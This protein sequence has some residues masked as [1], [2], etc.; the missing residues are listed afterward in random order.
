MEDLLQQVAELQEAMRRL[1]NIREAEKELDGWFQAQSAVDP[2]PTAKWPKT[3]LLAQMEG[4]GDNNVE[5][6]KLAKARTCRRKRLPP[7]PEVP[8]QNHFTALQTEQERPFT[9]GETLELSKA[10]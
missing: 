10:A 1:C 4:R 6:W 9:S 8:L 3:P 2:Q 7:K 5:E